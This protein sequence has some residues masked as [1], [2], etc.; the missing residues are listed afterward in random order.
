MPEYNEPEYTFWE[1]ATRRAIVPAS[2]IAFGIAVGYGVTDF[3]INPNTSDMA[4]LGSVAVTSG[5]AAV[6]TLYK[7]SLKKPLRPLT[8]I[9]VLAGAG[10]NLAI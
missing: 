6:A 5:L 10:L 4:A 1:K 8:G 7:P 2:L 9:S 3:A